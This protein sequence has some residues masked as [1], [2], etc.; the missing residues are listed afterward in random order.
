AGGNYT[1][2]PSREFYDFSPVR[3]IFNDLGAD[4]MA[5][6]TAVLRTFRIGGRVTEGANG[7]AGVIVN[8]SGS[9]TATTQTDAAGNYLFTQLPANGNYA[10]APAHP[11]YAF[12]PGSASFNTLPFNQTA[13]FAAARH[14][15]QISG[16]TLD[17]C[18]RPIPGVTMSLTHDGLT[19]NAQTNAAGFYSFTGVQAGYN[20][21]LA[22]TGSTHAFNPQSVSFPALNA[23]QAGNFTGTPPIS[24]T[25]A[26][27]LA[28]TYVRGGA[29]TSNF[30]TAIQLIARLASQT[31]DTYE[32]YVK[33]D[34]GRP[35]TVS[36]VKLRLY[37]KL[38]SSGT[39][40]VAVY[41]VSATVWTE[42][43]MNWNN[44]PLAGSLLRTVNVVGT[45][46]AW[47]EWDVTDYV[48]GELGAG[49]S[50]VSFVLKSNATTSYQVV[51]N[52][53]EAAGTNAPRLVV[54]AQ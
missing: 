51:F 40:P 25:N 42:T 9:Q 32:T 29:A 18:G 45:T 23:N 12:A 33:F 4:G 21:T 6:F 22:P 20:Y 3:G 38:S 49:R 52:S 47:Y 16:Y 41:G 34:A 28:D 11:F 24:I 37:G 1:V 53:R 39:L 14:L 43:G 13:N 8:L 35:C 36:S 27:A 10:V 7:V 48:R 26:P 31:K 2:Q 17:V 30:G 15:Y 54:T 5:N 46:A 44:K 50:T 19:A